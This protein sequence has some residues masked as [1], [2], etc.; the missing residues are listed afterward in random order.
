MEILTPELIEAHQISEDAKKAIEA[1]AQNFMADEKK[2]WD[3]QIKA[4]GNQYAEGIIEGAA[5]KVEETTGLKREQGEKI[6]DYLARSSETYFSGRQS[7][8]DKMKADYEEK[9]KGVTGADELQ[10]ELDNYRSKVDE[11][12]KRVAELEP[13]S[14]IDEK[15]NELLNQHNSQK[16][17]IAF[18]SVKPAFSESVNK[19]EADHKWNEFKN[20]VLSKHDIEIVDNVPMAIDKENKHKIVK[21]ED[22]VNAN[23]TLTELAKGRQQNGS[24]AK[25]A[26]EINIEGVP[27]KVPKGAD[28]DTKTKLVREHLAKEGISATDKGYAEQFRELYNKISKASE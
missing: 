20:D 18:N 27:F 9:I 10:K 12:Q 17:E 5:K 2:K 19:Y 7:E 4:E 28:T 3:D 26:E 22:L 24:G 11:Y 15:Y 1:N 6:A 21:L 8:L 14:G 25:A 16:K 13:L 23:E